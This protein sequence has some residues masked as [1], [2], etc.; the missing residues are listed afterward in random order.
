VTDVSVSLRNAEAD[1]TIKPGTRLDVDAIRQAVRSYG[2]TPTWIEF[3][4]TAELM[5][6]EGKPALT[7]L[8]T[9]QR[10]RLVETPQLDALRR[11]LA[12]RTAHV[13]VTAVI[14]EGEGEVASIKSFSLTP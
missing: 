1:F 9:G 11:A 5:T 14:S 4:V 7:L 12:G 10:I 8:D 3:T 2:F 6:H 13:V